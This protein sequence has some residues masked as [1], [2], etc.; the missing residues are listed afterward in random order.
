MNADLSVEEKSDTLHGKSIAMCI[1]SGIA[2][3]ETPKL[4]RELRRHGAQVHVYAA[5]DVFNF[6]GKA[7]LEWASTH[8]VI[9]SLSG[10]AEH[11]CIEDLVLVAPATLNTINKLHNGIADSAMLTLIASAIGQKKPVLL[12]PTMHESLHEHPVLRQHLEKNPM[13]LRIIPPRISEDKAKFPSIETIVA[14][15]QRE[16]S[17]KPLLGKKILITGG[18]TPGKIDDV[19]MITTKFRGDLAVKIAREAYRLGAQV[20]LLVGPTGVAVPSHIPTE[21]FGDFYEYHS[22][23]F[24][25]LQKGFHIGIFSAAVADYVPAHKQEGKIPSGGAIKTIP[26]MQTPKIIKE[27]RKTF[28]ELFMVTFKFEWELTKEQLLTIAENR[29]VQGYQL[30]VANRSQDIGTQHTAYIVDKSGI[31]S[32]P[33]SKQEIAEQL[34][35]YIARHFPKFLPLALKIQ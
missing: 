11:I 28:P 20:Q 3:I 15:V 6:I 26:L 1:S 19:R 21:V 32:V 7:A 25:H 16:L 12:V 35:E 2:A 9:T 24:S 29:I 22:K 14:E 31:L 33:T 30:V 10:L 27:V 34:M 5:E 18:P 8:P 13:D 17:G 4:I 23:V